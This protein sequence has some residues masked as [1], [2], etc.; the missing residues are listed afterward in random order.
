VFYYQF[1]SSTSNICKKGNRTTIL[2][3]LYITLKGLALPA[4]IPRTNCLAYF[5]TLSAMKELFY[6]I[7][8]GIDVIKN[9]SFIIGS[10]K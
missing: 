2:D 9:S 1:F 5:A 8:T 3:T 7:T 4:K 10:T 6:N